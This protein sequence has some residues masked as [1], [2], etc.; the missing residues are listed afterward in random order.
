ML[1]RLIRSGTVVTPQGLFPLDLGIDGERVAGLYAPGTAPE[2]AEVI[3]AAGQL[4]L[5][6]AIDAHVHTR[7]PFRPDREEFSAATS[8]AAAGGVTTICEMPMSLP[9]TN[10]AAVVRARRTF[11]E[12]HG[13]VDFALWGAGGVSPRDLEGMAEEGVCAF[14]IFLHAPMPGREREF[15]GLYV[16]DN[17]GLYKALAAIR[18][19]GRYCALHAEDNDLIRVLEEELK[20]AGRSDPAAHGESRPPFV[21]HV[22]VSKLLILAAEL[23]AR[24]YLPHISTAGALQ[25]AAE[26][27]AEDVDVV[28]E[29]CPHYLLFDESVM[30]KVGPYGKINPPM[31]APDEVEGVWEALRDGTVDIYASDHSGYTVDEKEPFW[32]DIWR[33]FPGHPGVETLVPVLLDKVLKGHLPWA[34]ALAVCCEGPAKAF[35]FYPRKGALLPGSDADLFLFDPAG[36]WRIEKEKLFTKSR[37]NARLYDGMTLRGRITCTLVRGTVVYEQGN[38]VGREGYGRFVR[39]S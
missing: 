24:L 30:A 16:S 23:E 18:A 34:R 12:E 36:E 5:P 4:V 11:C 17:Y 25:M 28:V 22:A 7:A 29:T 32:N 10:S 35:G 1:D 20:A 2:A 6:G 38:I 21:E 33:A 27:K 3:D 19:T 26:A 39:P 37:A 13:F 14:K 9:P 15:E 31:R 8:G